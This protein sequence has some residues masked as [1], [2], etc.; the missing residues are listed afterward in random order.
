MGEPGGHWERE[1][2]AIA[3][4]WREGGA[5]V[6]AGKSELSAVHA[7]W[8]TTS[9][10]QP[11]RGWGYGFCQACQPDSLGASGGI[12]GG[13]RAALYGFGGADQSEAGSAG[14]G[15]GITL[16]AGGGGWSIGSAVH[17]WGTEIFGAELGMGEP[18]NPSVGSWSTGPDRPRQDKSGSGRH[19]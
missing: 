7:L 19:Q 10:D 12:P 11:R 2:S 1:Q 17:R 5:R 18:S 16:G 4:L 6:G 3:G 13:V 9:Y 8:Q 15:S 14:T